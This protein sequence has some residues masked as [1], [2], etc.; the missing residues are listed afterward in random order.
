LFS[1][2]NISQGSGVAT[3]VRCGGRCNYTLQ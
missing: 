2:I 3:C 1:D